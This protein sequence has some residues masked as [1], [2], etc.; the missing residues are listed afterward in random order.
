MKIGWQ[1]HDGSGDMKIYSSKKNNIPSMQ[2]HKKC[3][4][5]KGKSLY[6]TMVPTK[7]LRF[8]NPCDH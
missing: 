8:Q 5:S 6:I 4:F 3:D 2:R 7:T 1:V